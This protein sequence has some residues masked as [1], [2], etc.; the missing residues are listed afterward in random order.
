MPAVTVESPELRPVP[1][2]IATDALRLPAARGAAWLAS[3]SDI[4]E[5]TAIACLLAL[6]GAE[7][8]LIRIGLDVQDEGYFVEQAN[9]V[10]HGELPFRDFDSLYTPAL[11]YIHALLFGAVGDAQVLAVRAVGLLSRALLA[12]SL[13]FVCRSLVRPWFAIIP[14]VYV[15]VGL[16]RVPQTWEPHPGW[17]S[18]ALTAFTVWAFAR[19][20]ERSGR[21]RIAW[22]VAIGATTAA[23]FAFKQNAGVF[24]ALALVAFSAWQGIHHLSLRVTHT[25]RLVQLLLLVA[26]PAMMA[27]LIRPHADLA[28]AAYFLVPLVA[29]VIAGIRPACVSVAG[30]GLGSWFA[31]LGLLG[32]GACLVTLPWL[33]ALIAALDGRV[34]LLRGFVGA[35]N[36]DILWRPLPAPKNAAWGSVLGIAIATAAAVRWRRRPLY[37]A[38]AGC[39]AVLFAVSAVVLTAGPGDT[40]R[41]AILRAP[42]RAADGMALLLPVGC[43]VAGAWQSF[44]APPTRAGWR[45]RWLTVAGALAFLTE[46]PRV[47]EMHL[48]WSA[49]LPLAVGAVVL[50]RMSR[51]LGA[52]WRVGG[53]SQL[54]LGAALLAVPVATVVP[55]LVV[56][57]EGFVQVSSARG[58]EF[59]PVVRVPRMPGLR[60]LIVTEKQSE[61]VL[62]AA[63][64]V[65]DNATPGEP[66][67]VYPSSP[68]VY[69]MLDR[70]NPT[71]F[72]HLYPGAAS[73]A[74][75]EE[76]ITALES[77]PVRFVVVSDAALMF[78]G[79]PKANAPLETYLGLAYRDVA[80]FG[81]YRV[82]ERTPEAARAP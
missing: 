50:G 17:P 25:L 72:A 14:A 66:I 31:V 21:Q 42:G 28:T 64:Y 23:V 36:Q 81:E 73:P 49:G 48:A 16:D 46:Y 63:R 75:L 24:L 39:G 69:V 30:R 57:S 60:G 47:D 22:L 78:W 29:A 5:V 76:V 80:R 54:A 2:Q 65:E 53:V 43:I 82:L 1:G 40:I 12:G 71:R 52:Y 68:M 56:R 19:L 59:A 6:L 79:L 32:L 77:T 61:T 15:L 51:N 37:A 20:P 9:R 45:L 18:A 4:A 10:L 26:I 33:T 62:T 3:L 8:L 35:V 58:V 13:Y 38:L 74:E 55:N 44:Y 11:L 7:L 27:W 34:D 67:F 41:Q 70:P